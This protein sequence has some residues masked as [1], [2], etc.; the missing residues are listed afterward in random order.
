MH[1][2]TA[3]RTLQQA[4][5]GRT[6]LGA[7]AVLLSLVLSSFA[8]AA[9]AE[10]STRGRCAARAGRHHRS[11]AKD[12]RCRRHRKS[13]ARPHRLRT[14]RHRHASRTPVAAPARGAQALAE[15]PAASIA[16]VLATPCANTGLTPEPSDMT[17]VRASILCLINRKRAE[18]GE[19]PLVTNPQLEAAAESHATELVEDDYFAHVSPSGE[20]PLERIRDTGYFPSPYVGYVVGENLAWGTYELATPEAIADAWFASPPHLANILEGEYRQTGIAVAPAVPSSLGGGAPGATYAQE[21][22]VIVE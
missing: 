22:G 1:A 9:V 10:A 12:S 4:G 18:N 21:F 13:A 2:H 7:F 20:T 11:T 6:A 16:A 14:A 15:T 8:T 17:L 3:P 5:P 19:E